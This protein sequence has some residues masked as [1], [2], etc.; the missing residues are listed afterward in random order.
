MVD[1]D[2]MTVRRGPGRLVPTDPAGRQVVARLFRALADPHRLLLLE[3]LLDGERSVSD[4]VDALGLAQSR[5]STHLACLADCGYLTV[6]RAGR[7]SLYRVADP[8]VAQLVV[9]ARSLAADNAAALV[10]CT[11]IGE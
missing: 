1:A 11:R 8:R 9:L 5:V 10:A 6:R 4:C 2:P 3:L 7:F